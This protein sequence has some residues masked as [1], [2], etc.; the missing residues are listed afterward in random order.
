MT[1]IAEPVARIWDKDH[2]LRFTLDEAPSGILREQRTLILPVGDEVSRWLV[3]GADQPGFVAHMTIDGGGSRWAAPLDHW[4]V[5]R[6]GEC[7]ECPHCMEKVLHSV[8]RIS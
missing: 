6:A 2:N 5:Q 8:W 4:K 3:D 1:A 7:R